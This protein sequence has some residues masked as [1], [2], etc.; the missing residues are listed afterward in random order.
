MSTMTNDVPATKQIRDLLEGLLGRDVDIR[1]STPLATKD[2]RRLLT[3][4][5]VDDSLK[6]AAVIGMDLELAAYSGA[7]MGLVPAAAARTCVKENELTP[8]IAENVG[9]VLNVLSGLLNRPGNPHV[10]LHQVFQPGETPPA[11]AA[12]RLLALGRRLDLD[13][14]VDGYGNGRLSLSLVG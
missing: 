5:Y 9:E 1:D 14:S 4:L 6:L 11:D 7:A 8:M 12:S 3:G 13:N 10:R 2:L